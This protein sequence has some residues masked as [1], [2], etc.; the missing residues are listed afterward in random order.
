MDHNEATRQMMVERY[1]LGELA[2][3]AQEAFEAHFFECEQCALDLRSEAE[4]LD[5]SKVV[6]T[7]TAQQPH[8]AKVEQRQSAW[9]TWFKPAFVL[10]VVAILAFVASYEGFVEIPKTKQAAL[11]AGTPQ[12]LPAVSLINAATRGGEQA[13][14][15]VGRSQPFLLF[16]DIPA[17]SAFDSYTAE[18]H[19]PA[20]RA[21]WSLVVSGA[22]A[23]DTV[24]IRVPGLQQS[25]TYSL[26]VFGNQNGGQKSEVGRFPFN[27]QIAK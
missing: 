8:A 9:Q 12:I 10:P 3:D 7:G 14:L 20:G 15:T 22:T 26:V 18:M 23:K 27:L 21:V 16:V 11:Q 24:Q 17:Q 13:A 6:L 5:H 4:F 2:P 19:D 1:L 25:G